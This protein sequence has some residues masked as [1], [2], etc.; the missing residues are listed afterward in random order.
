MYVNVLCSGFEIALKYMC[1]LF[2]VNVF[3]FTIS[4]R[5]VNFLLDVSWA[6]NDDNS[7]LL[8]AFVTGYL[9]VTNWM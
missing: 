6:I 8:V 4:R 3:F 5:T 2:A 7:K 9:F 1:Y